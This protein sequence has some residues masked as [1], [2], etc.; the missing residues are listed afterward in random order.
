MLVRLGSEKKV[1]GRGGQLSAVREKF[2]NSGSLN[3]LTRGADIV[4]HLAGV[5]HSEVSSEEDRTRVQVMNVGGAQNVLDSAREFG[6]RRVV[7]A[8]SAHVYD[9]Q[10]GVDLKEDA[11]QGAENI[12]AESK[13]QIERLAREAS[14][15]GLEV[16]IARPCLTYG[17][18]VA[19]NL[20]RLMKAIDREATSMPE[21]GKF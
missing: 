17:P 5:A 8:S 7:I 11:Q 14:T 2:G 3:S 15:K 20:H 1:E 21:T 13:I 4:I 19:F 18:G 6:V 16:V 12:Y 10:C 9:G